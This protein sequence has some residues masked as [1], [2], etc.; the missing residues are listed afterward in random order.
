MLMIRVLACHRHSNE[1]W[2]W[3][4]NGKG[5]WCRW[6]SWHVHS[7][8][9]LVHGN[10]SWCL[11]ECSAT[12]CSMTVKAQRVSHHDNS[13]HLDGAACSSYMHMLAQPV[14]AAP[15]KYM[16]TALVV[17]TFLL[18]YHGSSTLAG[19]ASAGKAFWSLAPQ[20]QQSKQPADRLPSCLSG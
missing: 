2:P 6:R 7:R 17:S 13:R 15:S 16:V 12:L 3:S 20:A 11:A 4:S 19:Y 14:L 8:C 9:G 1:F 5:K 10:C 18:T